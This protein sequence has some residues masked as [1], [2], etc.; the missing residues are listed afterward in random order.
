MSYV[1]LIFTPTDEVDFI[2]EGHIFLNANQ[3][4]FIYLLN[5]TIIH[6]FM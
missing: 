6:I 5:C 1:N 3:F 2:F 4:I